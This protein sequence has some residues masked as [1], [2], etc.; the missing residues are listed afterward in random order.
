MRQGDFHS[1]GAV[2]SGPL[3]NQIPVFLGTPVPVIPSGMIDPGGQVLVDRYPLPNADPAVTGGYNFV[4]NP[5]IDQPNRQLLA[6]VDWNV[7][8]STKAFLRYNRQRETQ[9]F[10]FGMWWRFSERSLPNPSR[11]LGD[12]RSDSITASLTH[13]FDP[14]LTSET[15]VS[16]TYIDFQNAYEDLSEVSRSDLGY[17]YEGVFGDSYDLIPAM[18]MGGGIDAGPNLGTTFGFQPSLFATKWQYAFSQ[19]VTK[20]WGTHTAKLGFFWERV[21]NTQPGSGPNHGRIVEGYWSPFVN[22]GNTFA[23]LL[24]GQAGAYAEQSE[25][26]LHDV[27]WDRWELWAQD[28]WKVSPRVTLNYGARASWF[29]AAEDRQGNGLSVWD[30]SRYE[31]DLAAGTEFPGIT[32]YARDP[33]IPVSG[34]GST[35]GVQPRVGLAWDVFG[36]GETVLRG[37]AGL[38]L[39]KNAVNEYSQFVDLGAGV[40]QFSAF[41]L[42][43]PQLEGLDSD[44]LA[45]GGSAL[46]LGEDR[47]PR[48][49]NWS[50]S[51][52]QRLPWSLN[53][54]LG[55]VGNRNDRNSH[56]PNLN[57]VPLGAMLDD[58][59]GEPNDYRPL[60]YYSE[61]NIWRHTLFSEYHGLQALLARQRGRINFTLA[62]TFSKVLGTSGTAGSEYLLTPLRDFSYGPLASDRT[63][64]ATGTFSWLLPEPGSDG[65]LRHLLGGWQ[66]SGILNY[67]SGAP[68]QTGGYNAP[69]F[70]LQGTTA[71][72]LPL[73]EPRITG[74]PDVV[75]M[76]VLTCDPRENVPDGYLVNP[77]CFAAPAPGQNGNYNLPYIKGQPYW[78]VDLAVFKNFDLGGDKKLQLRLSAYN[79]LNHPI[80]T[81]EFFTHLTMKFDRGVLDPNFGR[82][83]TEDDPELGPAN[84]YGRRIVQLA[85]RFTF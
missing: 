42:T 9:P 43:L 69:N 23:D 21:I 16:F 33:S 68:L 35:F 28:S 8:S 25:N 41:G 64:V 7:S 65:A 61:L 31:S 62:Y 60:Q 45:F 19:N 77:A 27:G 17:P 78:N 55:Y 2:G 53:L 26:V 34:I 59:G 82:L 84:K 44:E 12:N 3:V 39:W 80:A 5:L 1:A 70:A 10:A 47:V 18:E 63:H 14:T 54:E 58:P 66:L 15:I 57:A 72:G 22:T 38:Y 74:T 83:P 6:R 49:W 46:N 48:S 75:M 37:G 81:P 51:L 32:W 73:T 40:R 4:E 20:V 29:G 85:V 13:V 76:P 30:E 67:V 11:V 71:D 52:N 24:V 56:L 36:D 50:L 79:A